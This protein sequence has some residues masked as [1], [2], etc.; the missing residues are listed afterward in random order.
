MINF[1][2]ICWADTETYC[3]T[4]IKHGTH[5]YAEDVEVMLFTYALDDG[6]VEVWD[7]THDPIMPLEL[8]E[9]IADPECLFVF[10]NSHFDR[11]VLRHSMKIDIPTERIHD[12]MVQA[13]AHGLPGGLD[14]LCEVLGVDKDKAKDKTGKALIQLFCKPRPKNMT[15]RRATRVT[16]PVEWKQFIE[17]ARRDITSM[18]EIKKKLPMWNY[19]HPQSNYHLDERA[20][21]ELDQCINDRGVCMDVELA[22]R[23]I[24]AVD[25]AKKQLAK[26]TQEIT[27]DTVQSTTQRDKLLAFI[28]EAY[29]V[30]LPDMTMST[31][32]RRINDDNLP[33]ELRELLAI[34]LQAST[35]STSKYNTLIRGVSHD[36]RLRGCLQFCGASRTGRW[37]GRLFQP[38]NLPRPTL[39][40]KV[41]DEGIVALKN[42]VADLLYAN[43]MELTSSCIRGCIVAPEGK[44]LCVSDLSNIEGRAAAYIAGEEWKLEAFAA[45]DNKTGHD[46]YAIA[47]AK[48]FDITPEE[49]MHDKEHGLGLMRQIGKVMELMLQYEGGVGA[50]ITGAITYGIDLDAMAEM[51]WPSIPKDIVEQA[52]GAWEWAVK[53]RS[54]FGLERKTYMVCDA[55]KRMWREAH[56]EISNYWGELKLTVIKA[57]NNKGKTFEAGKLKIRRDGAWLRIVLPSGRALCY[58]SPIAHENG[59][60]SYM[61]MNQYSK[62][63]MRIYTYGGKLF[64]NICQAFA[65]DIM[66][67]NM[68]GIEG[69]GYEII[70]SVHDELITEAPDTEEYTGDNL[71]ELLATNPPWAEDMPLAA[72]GFHS[73]RYRK[74]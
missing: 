63:W 22:Q 56:P 67:Y 14:I 26:R 68:Q 4:P 44:R 46:L 64:E 13:L 5:R 53:K 48:A 21:W 25:I 54:T 17:Y 6:P 31:L 60:I 35:T 45:Y 73:Q 18:R 61:G 2:R 40:Q 23:A 66:A 58:P 15:L 1:K 39:K 57:I 65:R 42:G 30:D 49:V 34:R 28:L 20:M 37:A 11:T 71:S 29:G 55:L 59:K 62:K 43:V 41:I 50:F 72:G 8:E 47:Y 7:I 27:F 9:A 12:T 10:Q 74:D 19:S 3:E 70:L 32:E 52:A 69:A 36:N 24:E 51:A 16:H 38:Q 33:L